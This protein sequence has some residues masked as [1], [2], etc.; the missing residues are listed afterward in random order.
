MILSLVLMMLVASGVHT[1]RINWAHRK[2]Q[3]RSD[4]QSRRNYRHLAA[5]REKADRSSVQEQLELLSQRHS[6]TLR[7]IAADD[8]SKGS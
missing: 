6:E 2:F 3:E 8:A 5:V 7:K 4:E 1:F